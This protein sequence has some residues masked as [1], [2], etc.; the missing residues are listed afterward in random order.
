MS[1]PEQNL[2]DRRGAYRQVFA[3]PVAEIV[4]RDLAVF[5]R[6]EES[7]FNADA[8]LHAML[9]GRREVWLR[10][11][12]Y[13]KLSSEQLLARRKAGGLCIVTA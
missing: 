7:T 6:A 4:L 13:L 3:G 12:E 5:C 10:I 9:E 1:T 2:E 8:R 11:Q